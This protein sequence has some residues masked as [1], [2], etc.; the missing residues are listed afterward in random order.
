MHDPAPR[1]PEGKVYEGEPGEPL[2]LVAR[3]KPY[4]VRSETVHEAYSSTAL[5]VP[6]ERGPSIMPVMSR[7]PEAGM[8]GGGGA[9]GGEG[10]IAGPH[11]PK[12]AQL[13]H[14]G[15]STN[16]FLFP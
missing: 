16:G 2:P 9:I 8:R 3:P 11:S 6:P 10:G 5:G 7:Q 12:I 13:T 1:L 14:D 4:A 15:W